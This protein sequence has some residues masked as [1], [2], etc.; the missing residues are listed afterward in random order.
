MSQTPKHQDL[1]LQQS[2]LDAWEDYQSS[3][4]K[5]KFVKWDYII[6]TSS[7]QRQADSYKFQISQRLSNGWLSGETVYEVLPDPEGKRVGSGGATLS[8]LKYI[9]E[10]SNDD[11][12]FKNKRILVIHSGG[13][14][15]RVPQYS[16][17][18]KLFSPV[19]RLLPDG[20]RST[21]F[22]EFIIS[23]SGV[24]SRMQEGMLIL[25]GDVLLLFNPLQIDFQ[26]SGAAAI[27]I[28]ESVNTGKNHGVFLS[29]ENNNVSMFLHK[30]SEAKLSEYGA[31]DK[32]GN[33][34]IDTGAVFLDSKLLNSMIGL[35]CKNNLINSVQ[36]DKF[37]NETVRLNFYGD[38]LYPLASKSTRE[39][40][41]KEAPENGFSPLLTDCRNAIW[42]ALADFDM[43]LFRM[44]PAKF[45][46]FGTT[47]ELHQL[48]VDDLDDYKFLDWKR[49]V[50]CYYSGNA[51]F[52]GSNCFVDS[53]ANVN[54]KSYLE[55]CEVSGDSVVSK[56]CVISNVKL[57]NH[58]IP[59]ST[60]IHG[61]PLKNGY[62]VIRAYGI[63]DNPKE[64]MPDSKLLGNK[65]IDIIQHYKIDENKIWTK[66]A[67]EP[68]TL[69][70]AKLYPKLR[71]EDEC[72]KYLN[73]IYNIVNLSAKKEVVEQWLAQDRMSLAE[74]YVYAD[75]ELIYDWQ[76]SL[77]QKIRIY[78]FVEA[79]NKRRLIEESV[80]ELGPKE[81]SPQIIED[82][83]RIAY[84]CEF[85]TRIRIYYYLSKLTEGA[86]SE[87]LEGLCFDDIQKTLYESEIGN[88]DYCETIKLNDKKVEIS[89]PVRVNFG[90]GWSDTPP[91]CNELGGTVLNAAICLNGQLPVKV[92][93]KRIPELKVVLE[94]ADSGVQMEFSDL[95][96]LQNCSNPFDPVALHKAALVSCGIIP[97]IE[98]SNDLSLTELL[99]NIGGGIYLSTQVD[100][101]PRGSGLGTSSILAGGCVM[102]LFEL[103]GRHTSESEVFS[104]VVAMEQ[105]MSTGGGWQ[106][107]VGGVIPGIKY[108]TS[109]PGLRQQ[110]RI[111]K[112]EID[113]HV[114]EELNNR[115]VLIYTGQRRLA[116]NLLRDV[117]GRY[118]GSNHDAV[119]ALEKI[120]RIAALMRHELEK[121]NID[122]FAE[123]LSEHW[124]LSKQ[125]DKGSTNTSIDQIFSAC[126][127]MLSGKMICGAG[128][129]GFLQVVLKKGVSPNDLSNR[130][131]SV[132][133]D[134]GVDVWECNILL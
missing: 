92:I 118:I 133:Q 37:V 1:F 19:P 85:S 75:Q 91:Y 59:E 62:F 84:Q 124:E 14:S 131:N 72:L 45:I 18:G 80:S 65:I 71:S 97:R 9:R 76:S 34:D 43:K 50:L 112:I 16:A 51:N 31:V 114:L 95:E 26:Q 105:I 12:C 24:P 115:F 32:F 2:M 33:V 128:G 28:K 119:Y 7:N 8:V 111:Q 3:L 79:I 57:N 64:V 4:N 6:I 130:L 36:Y 117:V 74:S 42:D 25:S 103:I 56:N 96:E 81:L 17:C 46:H 125:L 15:K 66:G 107:Q 101:V 93:A 40:Y 120:Q 10:H 77:E 53:K 78:R 122:S 21:L 49:T 30:Q 60:V 67:C 41:L 104:R 116:R 5:E 94:T 99:E 100:N 61:V 98:T 55:D 88:I 102:A 35:L 11:D 82:I 52:S 22:D 83:L 69:W 29:D 23:L 108:T 54:V 129:G 127:D 27:S 106:D 38:F 87:R 90:G 73:D 126:D 58:F 20:R 13:D 63:D 39:R 113:E 134:S 109:K 121:G 110:L 123:L 48:M 47:K 132:F 86:E 70:N 44:S 89:L 68:N